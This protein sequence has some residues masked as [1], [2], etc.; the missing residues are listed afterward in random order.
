[1]ESST[2]ESN[3]PEINKYAEL[4]QWCI[5]EADDYLRGGNN[6]QASEKGWGA[7]AQALKAIAESRG[8]NHQNHGLMVD[9]AKQVSDEQGRPDMVAMF[10]RPRRCI[11]ISMK[12]GWAPT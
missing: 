3:G 2:P 4:S 12:T 7:T 9:I 11:P 5:E 6:V 1:M 10:G 8:W